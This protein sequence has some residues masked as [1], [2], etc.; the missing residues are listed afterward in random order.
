LLLKKRFKM[1][2]NPTHRRDFAAYVRWRDEWRDEFMAPAVIGIYS[3]D[4]D[5]VA[6]F[7]EWDSSGRLSA[8]PR[9]ATLF[10]RAIEG[11]AMLNWQIKQWAEQVE[12]VGGWCEAAAWG[13]VAELRAE[14]GWLPRWV[15]AAVYAQAGVRPDPRVKAAEA[16]LAF[17]LPADDVAALRRNLA[18]RPTAM[19]AFQLWQD[20]YE[21]KASLP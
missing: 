11:K 4:A 15:W 6:A 9:D 7:A 18:G 13:V 8:M 20:Q 19:A 17:N 1:R 10:R 16:C 12:E 5:P 14:F 21:K 2:V 3:G